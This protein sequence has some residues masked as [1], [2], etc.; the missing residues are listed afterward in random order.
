[1]SRTDPLK[2]FRFDVE[3]AGFVRAG[4]TSVSG[5]THEIEEISYR[6]G[7]E[8]DTLRK[9]PG[10]SNF[11]DITLSRGLL[12]DTDMLDWIEQILDIDRRPETGSGTAL[13]NEWRRDII[14]RLRGTQNG[15]VDRIW[16]CRGCWPKSYT[17]SDLDAQE[18][19]IVMTE[20]VLCCEGIKEIGGPG[21]LT[22][23]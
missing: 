7:G 5:L 21:P 10:L 18:S 23:P 17:R 2:S 15:V 13:E 14:I 9:M 3:I 6:E 4:F 12:T 8:I 19:G 20:L 1:M 11:G 22:F 16:S